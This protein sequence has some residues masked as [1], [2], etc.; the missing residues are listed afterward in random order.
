[1]VLFVV[2]VTFRIGLTGYSR[3]TWL[4]ILAILAGA[5]LLGHSMFSY[6]LQ[7]TSATTVSVLILL[8]APGAA[9]LA[10][11]W[12]GQ[13]PHAATLP[14]VILLLIGVA[15]VILGRRTAGVASSD[16]VDLSSR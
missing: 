13:R 4:A 3:N 15:V 12:L 16:P 2:C 14:G 8:E 9:L 7:R 5:Q 10:W 11:L 6:A 1:L